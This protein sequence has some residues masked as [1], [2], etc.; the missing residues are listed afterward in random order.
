MVENGFGG[1]W[2]EQK[3][4]CLR[5]YLNTYRQ[6]FTKNPSASWFRT[7]YVDGFAGTGT[8]KVAE[9]DV[10]DDPEASAYLDGSAKI[11]LG[12]ASPFDNYLFIEK[13]KSR[14]DELRR[15]IATEFPQLATRCVFK[16]EDANTA[17]AAWT[18]ERDWKR[19]R[20]V[21]FLDPFGLQVSWETIRSLGDTKAVDLWYL[22]P[23]IHR[24]LTRDGIIDATWRKKL[25]ALL[26]TT[27]WENYFY[28]RVVEQD[29][30][31]EYE[32]TERDATVENI[33]RFVHDRLKTC[34]ADVAPSLVLRNSTESPLFVLCFAAANVKGAPVA[35][36]IANSLLKK[37][38]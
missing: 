13:S 4:R 25:D 10:A 21:V 14:V 36:R 22:F 26:G 31:G 24:L 18:R 7:W 30:F 32:R 34:F 15:M 1:D 11:A 8:R 5:E 6:I 19:E 2:T 23:C 9:E 3:L 20:A 35:I 27:D 16:Q 37:G 17:L 12:L 28:K 29:L 33:Q 38:T